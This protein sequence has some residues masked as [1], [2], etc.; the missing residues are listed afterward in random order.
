MVVSESLVRRFLFTWR[1]FM[2]EKSLISST[3]QTV[4]NSVLSSHATFTT[5]QPFT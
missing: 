3:S 1:S 4:S 5:S 2:P